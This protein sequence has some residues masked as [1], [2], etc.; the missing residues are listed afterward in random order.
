MRRLSVVITERARRE[1]VRAE[2][3][4]RANRELAPRLFLEELEA[5]LELLADMPASGL[6]VPSRRYPGYAD[7]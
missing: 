3:W 4:W 5:T 1:L 7:G 2:K 6:S